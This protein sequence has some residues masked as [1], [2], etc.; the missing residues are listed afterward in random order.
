MIYQSEGAQAAYSPH[1]K[2]FEFL[3]L[4]DML[5]R[6]FDDSLRLLLLCNAMYYH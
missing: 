1:R 4:R 2:T 5:L 6:L 3:T